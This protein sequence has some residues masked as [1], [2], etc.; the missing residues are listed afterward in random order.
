MELWFSE[1]HTKGVK[2][3]IKVDRQLFTGHSEFQRVLPEEST[4][5]PGGFPEAAGQSTGRPRRNRL[6]T[7]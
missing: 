3:S 2:F 5:I 1:R 4:G 7:Q 6:E